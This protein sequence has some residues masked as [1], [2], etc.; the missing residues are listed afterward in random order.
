MIVGAGIAG[1]AAAAALAPVCGRVVVIERD[2]LPAGAASRRGVPQSDQLHNI[3]SRG[4][5]HLEELLP[6]FREAIVA[7]GGVESRV[8]SQTH[9]YDVGHR[10]PTRDVG[11]T[12]L[13]AWRP[14]IEHVARTL[15]YEREN[16][17]LRAGL[18]AEHLLVGEHGEVI[19]VSTAGPDGGA[20]LLA[21]LVVD[22]SGVQALAVRSFGD[23]VPE[24][25]AT[26]NRWYASTPFSRHGGDGFWMVFPT[27]PGT[28]GG[29]ISPAGHDEWHVSVSGS[30]DDQPPTDG[31]AVLEYAAS[32]ED[33]MIIERLDGCTA[34][35]PTH[36]FRRPTATRYRFDQMDR[37]APGFVAVGDS[38]MSLNP[39][40][41]MGIASAAWQ[42]AVL[43][44]AASAIG[45]D[46]LRGLPH[47]YVPAASAITAQAWD[48]SL[49]Q[50]HPLVT[51]VAQVSTATTERIRA[52]VVALIWDDI[53]VQ[54]LD[55]EVWH[56]LAPHTA[57]TTPA[58]VGKVL[59][60]L[61]ASE[62]QDRGAVT[63]ER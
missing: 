41:G 26:F 11:L 37:P 1:L 34:L 53:D 61:E 4:L 3:L 7:A 19:G 42:A 48:L 51:A 13:S 60:R 50:A 52:A 12:I 9:L 32:L 21:D 31:A 10:L 17:E 30:F 15:L 63:T 20:V 22:A 62:D 58:M 28:R 25:R 39:L 47:E 36:L 59:E 18:R 29:L 56:L 35:G 49:L 45:P 24:E 46:G 44:D 40:L 5:R 55:S 8:G 23:E 16:V 43:R 2:E 57:M 27:A 14:A 54:R 6:G 33:P 38:A